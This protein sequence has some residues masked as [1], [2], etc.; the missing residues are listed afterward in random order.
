MI[1]VM[2]TKHFLFESY[3]STRHSSD[4]QLAALL[5]QLKIGGSEVKEIVTLAKS[6][7]YQLACQKHFDVTHPGH[8]TMEIR[9]VRT[10]IHTSI[11]TYTCTF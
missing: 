6:G 9:G 3:L 10:Y 1:Y 5:G 4:S 8:Q 2:Y 7:N 11:H